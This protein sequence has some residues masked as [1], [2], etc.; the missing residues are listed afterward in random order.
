M[1]G[2][3]GYYMYVNLAIITFHTLRGAFLVQTKFERIYRKRPFIFNKEDVLATLR[4][5]MMKRVPE[6]KVETIDIM[7]KLK[8]ATVSKMKKSG[9]YKYSFETGGDKF[10]Y[11]A[12]QKIGP[13]PTL[14][15]YFEGLQEE[16]DNRPKF[17]EFLD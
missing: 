10:T 1:I 16:I 14:D 9:D 4:I 15:A 7:E 17:G 6:D 3:I 5:K 2:I 8:E 11:Y 12:Q 13:K